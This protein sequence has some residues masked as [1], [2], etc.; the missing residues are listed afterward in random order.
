MA[1]TVEAVQ[2]PNFVDISTRFNLEER[3]QRG[4]QLF[5]QCGC[6]VAHC[7]VLRYGIRLEVVRAPLVQLRVWWGG[8]EAS[9]RQQSEGEAT[10]NLGRP[11]GR[12]E[13]GGA[14]RLTTSE[15]V[16]RRHFQKEDRVEK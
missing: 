3:E 1:D 12:R 8:G 7:D 10:T 11:Q 13:R 5:A 6:F 2:V 14:G 16:P 15:E 4:I 9:L